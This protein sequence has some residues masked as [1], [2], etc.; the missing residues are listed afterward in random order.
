MNVRPGVRL[1]TRPTLLVGL[2]VVATLLLSLLATA[3][4]GG[5]SPCTKTGSNLV[6]G[7]GRDVLCGTTDDDRLDGQGGNDELQGSFGDDTLIGGPGDDVLIG[8]PGNDAWSGGG[9]NDNIEVG[10]DQNLD[11][12]RGSCGTGTDSVHFDLVDGAVISAAILAFQDVEAG[13]VGCEHVGIAAVNEGPNV[14]LSGHPLGVGEGGRTVVRLH[15]PASLDIDCTGSLR[16]GIPRNDKQKESRP[17]SHYS[18]MAGQTGSV[19]ARLSRKDRATLKRRGHL[20]GEILSVE[21][22]KFGKKTTLA[23]VRLVA[24]H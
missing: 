19:P 17:A 3:D 15:C 14:V 7:S 4:S 24:S 1:L 5:A 16:L 22:G 20:T 11:H 6:G 9:G 21:E 12:L 8:G 23:S 18:L 10:D 2:V 13:W